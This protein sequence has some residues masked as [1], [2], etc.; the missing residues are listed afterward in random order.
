MRE[1]KRRIMNE[2]KVTQEDDHTRIDKLLTKLNANY[3]RSQIKGWIDQGRVYVNKT[4]TK[5]NYRCRIDD[6]I[7]WSEPPEDTFTIEAENIPL[8]IFYEDEAILVVNKI[9]GMVVHPSPGHMHGTVVNALLYYGVELSHVGGEERPGIVH[10]LDKD[11]SGLLVIAKN[12]AAHER[13]SKQFKD[14]TVVRNYVALVHG[15][16]KHE[17]GM[18]DAPIGREPNNRQRMEV[19]DD[20]KPAITHFHVL[21]TF[22]EFSYV[23]CQLE[24]GRTHQIRV[25]MKYIH[26]PLVGDKTY[27]PRKTMDLSGQALHA[28]QIGFYHPTTMEWLELKADLPEY[29]QEALE[30]VR[31]I[32]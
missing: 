31:K 26:H 12:D 21:E 25:H 9:K 22:P 8:D 1:R 17:K 14:H 10:R 6:H 27:G 16:I 24:T 13:L 3:S 15:E 23:A 4:S 5:A 11:T 20:G 18:I 28:N 2:Y 29:F 30:K 19:I 32:Y 7:T